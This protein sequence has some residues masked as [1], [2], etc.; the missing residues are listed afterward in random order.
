M[1]ATSEWFGSVFTLRNSRAAKLS[2]G[3]L[4]SLYREIFFE[5][6]APFDFHAHLWYNHNVAKQPL[7][8]YKQ[9]FSEITD[10]KVIKDIRIYRSTI[11]NIDG[12]P[13]LKDFENMIIIY[14]DHCSFQR[15]GTSEQQSGEYNYPTLDELYKAQQIDNIVLERDWDKITDIQSMDLEILGLW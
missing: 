7:C 9:E 1:F 14:H 3:L 15:C 6:F 11:D 8:G 2:R 12:N 4:G 5:I 10:M 13:L